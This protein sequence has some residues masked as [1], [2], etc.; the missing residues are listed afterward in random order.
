MVQ[1]AVTYTA[2]QFHG[3]YRG[4]KYHDEDFDDVLARAEAVGCT[5]VI[6][7][8]MNLEGARR[9]LEVCRRNPTRCYMTLGVHPYHAA[10]LYNELSPLE[11]LVA[12]G[13]AL[14]AEREGPLVAFGEIGLDY[15][16]LSRAS[17][18]IQQKSF[19]DQL[20]MATHF[21]LPLFLH[22]RD[23]YHDFVSLIKPFLPRLKRGGIVHS[24]A[25]TKDEML[26]LVKLG[27]DISV[28]GTSFKD[29]EQLEMVRAIPL[30][31]LQL[32]TDAP[33]CEIPASG[34]AKEY[35]KDA[36]PLPP[37]QKHGSFVKG[38]MVKARN[39]SCVIERVARVVAGIQGVSLTEVVEAAWRN[40]IKMFGLGETI[41]SI[42]VH[43]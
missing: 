26:G 29:K 38:Q 34:P 42:D 28:N 30:D 3:V 40:S 22:V 41:D 25:G 7:T 4:K 24:F 43:N 18:E 2:S 39:E 13:N 11:E 37:S 10:E 5:K 35:L 17:K 36:P 27:F 15:F 1:I 16:Y 12:L 6:L 8:T 31:R 33:W 21:D 14:M 20:E 9:N 23:S 19:V 32:E